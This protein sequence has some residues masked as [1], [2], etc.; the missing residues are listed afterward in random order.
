VLEL[1][2]LTNIIKG[3]PATSTMWYISFSFYETFNVL[4]SEP[5]IFLVTNSNFNVDVPPIY[6][7]TFKNRRL[8]QEGTIDCII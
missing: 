6:N 4:G 1:I 2:T 7:K 3:Y 8:V 5:G